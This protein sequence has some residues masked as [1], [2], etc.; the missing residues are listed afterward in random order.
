MERP[1]LLVD[2]DP[3][4][5][6]AFAILCALTYGDLT[7]VTT[8]SGNVP[9]ENTTRN[10][11]WILELAG[12]SHIPVH[13]GAAKPLEVSP[14]FSR[15]IHGA[16]GL[17]AFTTP[18]PATPANNTRAVDAITQHCARGG[19]IIV[20]IGPLT[21]IA[22]ALLEDPT[23]YKRI[24]H[25]HWMGGS[26]AAGNTTPHAEF[27][28]WADPH[29][30]DVVLNSG[31]PTSMYGLDLTYQVRLN[32]LDI[33]TLREAGTSTSTH[34]AE[35]LSHYRSTASSKEEGQPIHDACAV[36]GA[37]H[38]DLFERT[39]SHIVVETDAVDT[40]GKTMVSE[41]PEAVHR[42]VHTAAADTIRS[43]I[44]QAA[45]SPGTTA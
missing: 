1:A 30:V 43:M 34:L 28:A 24:G 27:N 15:D 29:A 14:A 10:A 40:R 5:D 41:A 21:N 31:C 17:G 16:S 35:F 20:A 33:A 37:T 26:A 25:L 32:D 23:L 39:P 4:I 2:C 44:L 11:Q 3:G 22:H 42:H 38:H 9:I 36:L 6:D 12:A 45:I 18:E 8:V 7:A 13:P 19:A